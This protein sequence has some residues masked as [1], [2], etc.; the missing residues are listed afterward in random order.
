MG[1]PQ[2]LPLQ[3]LRAVLNPGIHT[4]ERPCQAGQS[5]LLGD[6]L[7]AL[8]AVPTRR[9]G[10]NIA[11]EHLSPGLSKA[12]RQLDW[13]SAKIQNRDNIDDSFCHQVVNCIWK[14]VGQCPVKSTVFFVN[15]TSR[16]KFPEILSEVHEEVVV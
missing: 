1:Q 14:S 3:F 11:R 7:T 2:G 12:I 4:T 8:T 15:A 16:F 10:R 5:L 9:V 6:S 13:V